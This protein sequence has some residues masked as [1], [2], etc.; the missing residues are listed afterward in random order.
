MYKKTL[1]LIRSAMWIYL[2][3]WSLNPKSTDQILLQN[4]LRL[5]LHSV[6]G[7]QTKTDPPIHTAFEIGGGGLNFDYITRINMYFNYSQQVM[8]TCIYFPL[9]SLQNDIGYM[10][11]ASKQLPNP[12]NSTSSGPRPRG[13]EIPGSAISKGFYPIGFHVIEIFASYFYSKGFYYRQFHWP[14]R[15]LLLC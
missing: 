12:K 15:S 9:L 1:S 5:V 8:L 6:F 11:R 10:C 14:I 2:I 4:Q 13:F 7:C 3:V